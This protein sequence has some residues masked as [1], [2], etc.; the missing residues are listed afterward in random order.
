M[1]VDLEDYLKI[2]FKELSY[3]TEEVDPKILEILDSLCQ[4][5]STKIIDVGCGHNLYKEYYNKIVGLDIA[6][7]GADIVSSIQNA[8]IEEDSFD[9]ALCLGVYHGSFDHVRNDIEKI[10]SWVKPNGYIISRAKGI[11]TPYK[12]DIDCH[13]FNS[14][15]IKNYTKY[16]NFTLLDNYTKIVKEK[17]FWVWKKNE[18]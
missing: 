14:D 6:G 8:T 1:Q 17:Y 2:H 5:Y 16:F 7:H 12:I 13:Y 9:I 4:D 11:P 10:A 18:Y 15:I 3:R